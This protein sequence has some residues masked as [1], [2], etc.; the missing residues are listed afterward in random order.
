MRVCL[1]LMIMGGLLMLTACEQEPTPQQPAAAPTSSAADAASDAVGQV[2]KMVKDAASDAVAD[3]TVCP[4]TGHAVAAD[5][6]KVVYGEMVVGFC[7]DD[8]VKGFKEQPEK[9]ATSI[10]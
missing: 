5:G 2:A 3:N 7:C 9:Y 1:T 4:L 8:C 10:K 6:M